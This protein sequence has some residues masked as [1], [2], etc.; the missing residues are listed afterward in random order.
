MKPTKPLQ[1]VVFA[2]VAAVAGF[3][4]VG[5]WDSTF[6]RTFPVPFL[7]PVTLVLL[8][9]AIT[10]WAVTIRPRLMHKPGTEPI[11][12]F[13]AARTAA[14]AMAA[15][16]TG[17]LVAGFYLGVALAFSGKL[18]IEIATQRFWLSL[19]AAVAGVLVVLA[20]LWLEYICRLPNDDDDDAAEEL[21]PPDVALP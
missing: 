12:P 11:D 9:I 4:T 14:L 6:A 1:L 21:P 3:L 16:R 5:V 20:A 17:A 10:V 18:Y 19:A 13:T 2:V 7:A 15:S 8:A